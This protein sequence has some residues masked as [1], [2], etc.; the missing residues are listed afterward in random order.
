MTL[1]N[2]KPTK[3]LDGQTPYYTT[4][5][6]TAIAYSHTSIWAG[7]KVRLILHAHQFLMLSPIVIG[8]LILSSDQFQIS[9]AFKYEY[10]DES[11]YVETRDADKEA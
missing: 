5:T 1:D 9:L 7:K 4:T 11:Y 10:G 3:S 6:K 2:T 8:L